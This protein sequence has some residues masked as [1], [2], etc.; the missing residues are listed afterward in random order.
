MIKIS[1]N[2]VD[3]GNVKGEKG[4][5]GIGISR[6]EELPRDDVNSKRQFRIHFSDSTEDNP[7][8]FSYALFDNDL[9]K[10]LNTISEGNPSSDMVYVPTIYLLKTLLTNK[11]DVSEVYHKTQTYTK[12]EIND[13]IATSIGEMDLVE[14][15]NALPTSNIKT[16]RLYMLTKQS[17]NSDNLN[18]SF[19]LYIYENDDWIRLDGLNFSITDYMTSSQINN[20]LSSKQDINISQNISNDYSSTTKYPSVSA[21]K[22]YVDTVVSGGQRDYYT[23][24]EIDSM[25]S[26]IQ[27]FIHS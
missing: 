2:R 19:D 20:L 17:D 11:A 8:Y 21:V 25:I 10:R 15:V 7:H 27:D 9:I 6:I 4:I 18:P 23:K 12:S 24:N 22:D 13:L 16:N 5:Q 14:P 26:D 1:E 3:L